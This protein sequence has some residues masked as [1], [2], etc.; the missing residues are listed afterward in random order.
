MSWVNWDLSRQQE[1]FQTTFGYL[2]KLRHTYPSLRPKAFGDF[3]H[4]T[5]DHDMVKWYNFDGEIMSEE[6]WHDQEC[7]TIQR[8]T[9][10]NARNNVEALLLVIHGSEKAISL[11]LPQHDD[12][13]G[14]ELIWNSAH[15]L[16]PTEFEKF[17]PLDGVTLSGTSIQLFRAIF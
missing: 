6:N 7:R 14:Y 10:H 16:P 2:T 13:V 12:I 8:L 17:A 4:A 3:N 1:D 5:D 15:E 9:K 11:T